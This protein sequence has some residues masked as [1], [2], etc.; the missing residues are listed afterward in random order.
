MAV[1][2]IFAGRGND[3]FPARYV[4]PAFTDVASSHVHVDIHRS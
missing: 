1:F 3:F 4:Y 2:D